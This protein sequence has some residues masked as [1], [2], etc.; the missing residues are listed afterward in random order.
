MFLHGENDH[1]HFIE[2][3]SYYNMISCL[4][5]EPRF[6]IY[7]IILLSETNNGGN[8]MPKIINLTYHLTMFLRLLSTRE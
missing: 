6:L 1:E 4:R 3:Y 5:K 7:G 8:T 2:S